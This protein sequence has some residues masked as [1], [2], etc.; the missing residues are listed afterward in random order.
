MTPDAEA[1]MRLRKV[2]FDLIERLEG[3][4]EHSTD[5]VRKEVYERCAAIA[6]DMLWTKPSGT[7]GDAVKEARGGEPPAP[8]RGFA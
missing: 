5:P 3:N 8:F 1:L 6:R 4:A 7:L 2:A